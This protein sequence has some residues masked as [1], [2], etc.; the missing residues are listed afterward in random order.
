MRSWL[1]RSVA[2]R[3]AVLAGLVAAIA[4]AGVGLVVVEV[5]L[6]D[7]P[8]AERREMLLVAMVAGA[9]T[10]LCTALATI[11]LVDRYLARPL[12]ALTDAVRAAEQGKYLR[13]AR[14]DRTDELGQLQRA[15]DRLCSQITDLSVTVI[16]SDRE[17]GWMKRELQM[18]EAV[19]LLF[20]L[21]QTFDSASDLNA[22]VRDIPKR[23]AP[24]LGFEEMAILLLDEK[25]GMLVVRATYGFPEGDDVLGMTFS[26]GEGISGIVA[27][28]G[29]PLIIHDTATDQR[30]THYKGKHLADGSFVCVPMKLGGRVQGLFN[31]LRPRAGG[32]A[33]A[34]VALL[35]SLASYT[36]LAIA[37]AE[38]TLRL[39]DLAVTDELTNVAN[40]RLLLERLTIEIERSRRGQTA[41]SVLMIDLDHFKRV[42][43]QHGHL[44][45]D[46]V[47]RGVARALVEHVRR[48]DLVARYGGEEFVVLLPDSPRSQAVLVAEKL[49]GAVAALALPGGR[50][51]ISVGV[52]TLPDDAA[53]AEAVLEA[54]DRA[55]FAAKR[56]GRDR[57]VSADS[58]APSGP[59]PE[60]RPG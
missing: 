19:S 30:Y 45:G 32:F 35:R 38:A 26:P 48:A 27:Q 60:Q 22:I 18:K 29:E 21:T 55:L 40:R 2:R 39:R 11:V 56:A 53:G 5:I 37:H 20:E 1:G 17:L 6:R 54:A 16:D 58:A 44:V 34:D 42:N 41:L 47:L 36:A 49:R 33:D 57:V 52:A 43:D 4:A 24:V 8:A 46:E 3:V 7:E 31:V 28:S 9:A 50:L 59:V 12:R 14:T 13:S 10:V 51:T 25:T 15:F 23:V